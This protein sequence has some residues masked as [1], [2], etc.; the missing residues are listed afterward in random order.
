MQQ[1]GFWVDCQQMEK[2]SFHATVLTQIFPV[3]HSKRVASYALAAAIHQ[4]LLFTVPA[5]FSLLAHYN[6]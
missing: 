3:S 6:T 5:V 2:K 4:L 1:A